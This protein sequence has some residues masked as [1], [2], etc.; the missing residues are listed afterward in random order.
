LRI[1]LRLTLSLIVPLVA[2][3]VVIGVLYGRRSQ[4]ILHEELA[5]EGRAISLVVQIAITDYFVHDQLFEI[6]E[7]V[8]RVT[9][10]EHVLGL[11]VFDPVGRLV[12]Q[13]ASLKPYPFQ[14]SRQLRTV[15]AERK[16]AMT[17]RTVGRET[18]V[19]TIVPLIDDGGRLRGAVQVL[20]L[21][22]YIH[23]DMAATFN[24]IL[25]LIL[26]MAAAI[27]AIVLVVTRMSITRPI[28]DL[29]GSFREVSVRGVPA[30]VP[31]HAEDEFGWLAREFNGMCDRLHSAR[32]SLIAEQ[33]HRRDIETRLRNA[34]RLAGLGRLAAGL[35][36]EIGTPLNVISG[37]AESLL[38]ASRGNEL[39]ERHLRII[40][41]QTERITRIV[42]DMLDF[43]RKKPARRVEL[44][45]RDPIHDVLEL[46]E[47]QFQK[48]QIEV[49]VEPA[50]GLAAINGDP[51][52]LQQV[53]LNL[54]LNAMDAMPAGGELR[55]ASSLE[56]LSNPERG[57][58]PQLCIAV[59]FEDFGSG[60]LAQ[61]RNHV[62]DPFFTTKEAGQGT[63]LGL[64]VSYGIIEEHGGWFDLRSELGQ[65]TRIT[66]ILPVAQQEVATA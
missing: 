62:F 42:R 53:F 46:L 21:E 1:G 5:K 4:R 16:S 27:V 28:A 59:C 24:F 32:L 14:S 57:G 13:S 15:L 22:S 26:S 63:G 9:N 58:P 33:D 51:D 49:H 47:E 18:A 44:D 35:A 54:T 23:Q 64:A 38:R 2:L 17:H 50:D 37:R 56:L 30:G 6:E 10:Y 3:T 61:D 25:I 7:L 20:Q 8:D 39:A 41:S 40:T 19:G 45:L 66:V 65:G 34:E 36:H 52:Q 12:Y 43:A 60:I 11:R 48:R 55:I 29:V 31:I